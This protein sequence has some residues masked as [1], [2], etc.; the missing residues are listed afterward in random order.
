MPFTERPLLYVSVMMTG[1]SIMI[2]ELL[3][4]RIIAPFYGTSLYVWSSLISVTLIA[5][6]SGYSIG[7][8][9]SDNLERFRLSYILA[10]AAFSTA[11]IAPSSSPILSMTDSLG[12]R[13]GAF[14]S[15]LLLFTTPLTF[16]GMVCPYVIKRLTLNLDGIGLT[17]GLIYAISTLG[18]VMG[19]LLLVFLLL[20][21]FG[22]KTILYSISGSLFLLALFIALY[23]REQL[24][25]RLPPIIV[26]FLWILCLIMVTLVSSFT[27]V[28]PERQAFKTLYETESL[29]GKVRI[30]E[31]PTRDVRWMFSDV[32]TLSTASITANKSMLSY[33]ALFEALLYMKPKAQKAL[34]IGLGGGHI[35]DSFNAR[36]LVT[37]VI[38]I[39]PAVAFAAKHSF[40][41]KPTGK[42]FIGDAR[43]QIRQLKP[44]DY[45]LIIYDCFMDGS[46][47]VHLLSIE[48]LQSIKTR[49]KVGGILAIHFIGFTQY[50]EAQAAIALLRTLTEV[51]QHTRS[52]LAVPELNFSD[53]VFYASDQ[54]I[55]QSKID[56]RILTW[57]SKREFD[58]NP[59]NGFVIT[60]DFNP[61]ESMQKRNAEVYRQKLL[62]RIN[63]E[64]LL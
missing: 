43:Y 40:N 4:S 20:P 13:G 56:E 64:L 33:Q 19:T 24:E 61:L 8:W 1:A 14:V 27:S 34:L 51:F 42:L 62:E 41:F 38:E 2:L 5:L 3:G 39:N 10:L 54:P 50:P 48:A 26:V 25:I 60:D 12:V 6:A 57:L 23:E 55:L 53:L 35:V 59:Q 28:N 17:S 15:V 22:S 9:I 45:D 44:H 7:G 32:S 31:E 21:A 37:D 11:M 36:G 63:V 46:E 29:Y 47:F 16:L 30:I 58:L 18:S 52:Y 49:L